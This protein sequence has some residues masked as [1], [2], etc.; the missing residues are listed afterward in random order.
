MTTPPHNPFH[1][2]LDNQIYWITGST[3]KRDHL[4]G[5]PEK[6]IWREVLEE[7]VKKMMLHLFAWVVLTNHYHLLVR[8][9]RSSDLSVFANQLNGRSSF[10]INKL[11]G[12][13]GRKIWYQY[14]DRCI[15]GEEDFYVRF[16]YIHHNPVKHSIVPKTDDYEFSSYHYYLRK[17]GQEWIDDLWQAHP[18][19]DFTPEDEEPFL[20]K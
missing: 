20:K 14:W 16:N 9:D 3:F 10:Q 12:A 17:N 6:G 19:V 1:L 11:N 5:D 8:L 15:R 13:R 18:I 7:T 2:R 4:L